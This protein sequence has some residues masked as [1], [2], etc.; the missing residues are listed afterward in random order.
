MVRR[1]RLRE[2]HGGDRPHSI[3]IGRNVIM[4]FKR[5]LTLFPSI[6]KHAQNS[7]DSLLYK[8][9]LSPYRVRCLFQSC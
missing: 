5:V 3:N 4:C 7:Y 2:N 1:R 9:L 8:L 6:P